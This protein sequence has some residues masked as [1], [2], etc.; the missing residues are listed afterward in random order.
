MCYPC[1]IRLLL[2]C[3]ASPLRLEKLF[4]CKCGNFLDFAVWTMCFCQVWLHRKQ[5]IL[6][7]TVD[8]SYYKTILRYTQQIPKSFISK[9]LLNKDLFYKEKCQNFIV[10][11]IVYA[12]PDVAAY[13]LS[14]NHCEHLYSRHQYSVGLMQKHNSALNH[15]LCYITNKWETQLNTLKINHHGLI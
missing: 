15:C 14:I 2:F 8:L 11:Y 13:T 1:V 6:Y 3:W 10:V 12:E 7:I 5:N 9:M 4:C